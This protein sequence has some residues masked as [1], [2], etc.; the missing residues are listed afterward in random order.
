MLL[1][2]LACTASPVDSSTPTARSWSGSCNYVDFPATIQADPA[3]SY[4]VTECGGSPVVYCAVRDYHIDAA[5]FLAPEGTCLAAENT[6]KV[7][8]I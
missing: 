4:L 7:V 5:G 1:L 6:W 3:A 2:L 8:E